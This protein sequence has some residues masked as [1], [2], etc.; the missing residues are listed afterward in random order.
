M[1]NQNILKPKTLTIHMPQNMKNA[2]IQTKLITKKSK[3]SLVENSKHPKNGC[4]KYQ[5]NA[6]NVYVYLETD[7]ANKYR[8]KSHKHP[9]SPKADIAVKKIKHFERKHIE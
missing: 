7:A 5:K 9:S 1:N 8:F 3:N 6:V 4:A 2:N